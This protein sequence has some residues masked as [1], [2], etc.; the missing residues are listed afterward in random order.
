MF[1]E[2]LE[3]PL[4]AGEKPYFYKGQVEAVKAVQHF[5]A[6]HMSEDFSQDELAERFGISQTMMKNVLDNA[7]ADGKIL[8]MIVE[9]PTYNNESENDS[10]DYSLALRL[11]VRMILLT[12]RSKIRSRRW[13]E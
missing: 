7:I 10:S 5:L 8:P 11:P 13:R 4:T 12:H 6:E 2:A 9:C 3:L 1:L